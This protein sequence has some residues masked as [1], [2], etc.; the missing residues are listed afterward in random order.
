M[1]W[2]NLVFSPFHFSYVCL[3]YCITFSFSLILLEW[4]EFNLSCCLEKTNVLDVSMEFVFDD[5]NTDRG[6]RPFQYFLAVVMFSLII[7]MIELNHFLS[8]HCTSI[9][10]F[11]CIVVSFSLMVYRTVSV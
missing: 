10:L 7:W 11:C 6:L 2:V 9:C 3:C 1:D 5:H 8:F 4:C